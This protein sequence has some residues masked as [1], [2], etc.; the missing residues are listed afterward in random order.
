[1]FI[2]K[3]SLI[4]S[5]FFCAQ[6]SLKKMAINELTP[7]F[8][9]GIGI[10]EQDQDYYSQR[11]SLPAQ[12][13]TLE[14]ILASDE[15]NIELLKLLAQLYGSYSFGIL[16]TDYLSTADQNKKDHLKKSLL[17]NLKKSISYAHK[18][19]ILSVPSCTEQLVKTTLISQCM[20]TVQKKHVPIIFWYSFSLANIIN[21]SKNS[22]EFISKMHLMKSMAERV[23]ELDPNYYYGSAS[24][25]LMSYYGSRPAMMGG[26]IPKAEEYY[27]LA[28][29]FGPKDFTLSEVFYV[30]HVLIPKQ[31]KEYSLK[32]LKDILQ[33][34]HNERFALMDEIAKIRAQA[35][36]ESIDDKFL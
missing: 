30:K 28:K 17:L 12:G 14:V 35:M 24:L 33:T 18:A 34:E 16:E 20:N 22:V 21:H 9:N 23:V 27:E 6:C 10:F 4:V 3:I 29:K 1:M 19:L 25:I 13:K 31:D 15:E 8:Q 11:F 32:K 26:S 7:V 36:L 2:K 5:L